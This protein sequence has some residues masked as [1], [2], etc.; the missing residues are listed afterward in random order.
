MCAHLWHASWVSL[1]AEGEAKE[2]SLHP[3]CLGV[4]GSAHR[5]TSV[6]NFRCET[7]RRGVPQADTGGLEERS[8]GPRVGG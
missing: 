1:R 5:D 7:A 2:R 3:A 4:G 6:D 8:V